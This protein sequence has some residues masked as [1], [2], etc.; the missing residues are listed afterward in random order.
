MYYEVIINNIFLQFQRFL[1]RMKII[2][3]NIF[4]K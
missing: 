2:L 4:L 1:F 3:D